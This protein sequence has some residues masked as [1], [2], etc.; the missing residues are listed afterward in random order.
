[1]EI[2]MSIKEN[3]KSHIHIYKDGNGTLSPWGDSKFNYKKRNM[4][5]SEYGVSGESNERKFAISIR[6][7]G[8]DS[9]EGEYKLTQMNFNE[10]EL[11]NLRDSIDIL[12]KGETE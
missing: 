12:L 8:R 4:F 1:M 2:I 6:V 9:N 10:D 11:R 3:G 5:I 7:D